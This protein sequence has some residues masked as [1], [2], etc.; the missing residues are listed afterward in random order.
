MLFVQPERSTHDSI[1]KN[2]LHRPG[3]DETAGADT[4]GEGCVGEPHAQLI[5]KTRSA[6]P[7]LIAEQARRDISL[8]FLWTGPLLPQSARVSRTARMTQMG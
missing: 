7:P 3:S 6:A 5:T 4:G 8:S 2:P 1:L